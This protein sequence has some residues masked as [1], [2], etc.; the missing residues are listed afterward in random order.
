MVICEGSDLRKMSDAQHL[1]S[2]RE[3]FQFPANR[4]CRATADAGIY[5][6]E[7]QRALNAAGFPP[8]TTRFH[9]PLKCKH[10]S[11]KLTAGG[12]LLQRMHGLA[13]VGGNHE[14]ELIE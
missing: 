2:P 6:V 5:F 3:R 13:G 1:I 4:F 9:A 10:H 14:L 8:R 12:D 11:R 7:N